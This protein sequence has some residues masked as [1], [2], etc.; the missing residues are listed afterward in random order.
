MGYKIQAE[1]LASDI[2]SSE[3]GKEMKVVEI[4][5]GSRWKWREPF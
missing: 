2:A 4:A 3:D 1:E 5:I